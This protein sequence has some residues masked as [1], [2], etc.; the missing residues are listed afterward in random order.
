MAIRECWGENPRTF[1]ITNKTLAAVFLD[2]ATAIINEDISYITA[3][4]M[5]LNEENEFVLTLIGD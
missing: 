2:A 4:N 3:V 1:E 5:Y